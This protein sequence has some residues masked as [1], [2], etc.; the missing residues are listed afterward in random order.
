MMISDDTKIILSG[1]VYGVVFITSLLDVINKKKI[2]K[3]NKSSYY[4]SVDCLIATAITM[5]GFVV[6]FLEKFT[7]IGKPWI[8]HWGLYIIMFFGCAGLFGLGVYGYVKRKEI[9]DENA[10]YCS[11]MAWMVSRMGFIGVIFWW[12]KWG[13]N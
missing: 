11:G 5:P 9:N 10:S 7:D 2:K 4:I 8:G 3:I 12:F 13:L 6:F 1:L